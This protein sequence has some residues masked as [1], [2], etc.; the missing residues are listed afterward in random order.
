MAS[1]RRLCQLLLILFEGRLKSAA[2]SQY[3]ST[4][5]D[6]VLSIGYDFRKVCVEVSQEKKGQ[7]VGKVSKD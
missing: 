1:T 5:E 3:Q 4:E 2:M 6:N 7:M